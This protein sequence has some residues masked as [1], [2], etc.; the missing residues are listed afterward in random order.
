MDQD[1]PTHKRAWT[2][3]LL[4]GG[5]VAVTFSW[6]AP[7]PRTDDHKPGPAVDEEIYIQCADKLADPPPAYGTRGAPNDG[8]AGA[9]ALGGGC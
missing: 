1:K 4:L 2:Y 7:E 3:L 9:V 6:L 8:S 5:V